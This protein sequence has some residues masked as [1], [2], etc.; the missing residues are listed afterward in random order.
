MQENE[1]FKPWKQR[2][3]KGISWKGF[4]FRLYQ[5]NKKFKSWKQR[6]LK[7][8][9]WKG[10]EFV[11]YGVIKCIR[12]GLYGGDRAVKYFIFISILKLIKT[13]LKL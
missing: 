9:N 7:G 11:F 12:S 2:V 6:V 3:L 8:I 10:F 4:E 13:I 5:G 1:R